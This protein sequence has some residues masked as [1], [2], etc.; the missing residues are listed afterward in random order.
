VPVD[1]VL[2]MTEIADRMVKS[3]GPALLFEKAA[4]SPFPV[5][6]NL[7][8]TLPRACFALGVESFDEIAQRVI[9]LIPQSPPD[10]FFEKVRFLFKLKEI[11]GFQPRKIGSAPVQEIIA[12]PPNLLHLPVLKCWPKDAGRFITL[13]LVITRNPRTGQQNVGMYRIQ[14][15]SETRAIMHWHVHHDGAQNFRLHQD[16]GIDMDVAIVLGGD[17]ATIYSATA[18]LP[19][20]LDEL[21][22]AGFLRQE[23]VEMVPGKTV[24][25]MVPAH[26]EFVI[27]GSVSA[28]E[29]MV[30]GPFGDHTGFYSDADEYPVINIKTITRKKTPIYPAT[31]VGRPPMEDC[32]FGK[33]TERIFLPLIRLQLPEIT[34]INLPCEGVFHNCVMV[35][36]KK[37]YPGHAR[38]VASALWGM[39]QMMFVKVVIIVDNDVDVQNLSEVAWKAL[40]SIDP[41]RDTLMVKGPLDVLDHASPQFIYGSKIGIDATRKLKEEGH[42]RTWPEEIKMSPEI[43]DRV[44]RRWKEYGFE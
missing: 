3:G 41:E 19:P 22:F 35:A 33:A 28:T 26:A 31:I 27:E 11:G 20:G 32:Y 36:I 43:K 16:L 13:P 37:D 42:P 30:E 4:D 23:P 2:E 15:M 34:D 1:P 29:T 39:G 44:S 40:S 24:D 6:M 8:G 5:A 9:E 10:S 7:F 14:I 18:P 25:L 17:P 12:Q 38:K 21:I